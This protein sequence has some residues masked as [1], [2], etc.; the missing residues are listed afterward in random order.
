[1]HGA[2]VGVD[3]H[4]DRIA[5]VVEL[6]M[7]GGLSVRK[8]AA[9]YVGIYDPEQ[10][11]VADHEIWILI[12]AQKRSDRLHPLL[13]GAPEHDPAFAG[14]VA[15][16]QNVWIVEEPSKESSAGDPVHWHAPRAIVARVDV[17]LALGVIELRGAPF[18]EH[19]CIR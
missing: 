14:D 7:R 17:L 10:A 3:D 13:D 16:D 18:D 1:I 2:V 8:V 15:A 5:D 4:L 12:Q 11:L 6:S 9:G 19:V